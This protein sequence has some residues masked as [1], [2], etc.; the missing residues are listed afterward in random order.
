MVLERV[1]WRE[2]QEATEPGGGWEAFSGASLLA[3][4]PLIVST[5]PWAAATRTAHIA[6]GSTRTV[7]L[8]GGRKEHEGLSLRRSPETANG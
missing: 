6:V 3:L 1:R 2:T 7:A 8:L 5:T 4:T